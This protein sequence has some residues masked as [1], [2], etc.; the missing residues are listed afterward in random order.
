MITMLFREFAE[1][2][3]YLEKFSERTKKIMVL[4]EHLR[5]LDR[6]YVKPF[7]LL[8]VGKVFP[9]W[10][11]RS[12]D[13]S[14]GTISHVVSSLFGIGKSDMVRALK[15][16]GDVGDALKILTEGKKTARQLTLLS[17]ERELTILD[18][19]ETLHR[20]SEI[21]GED[22]RSRKE[23][24]LFTLMSRLSP[25]ELKILMRIIF[26]D[27]RHGVNVGIMEEAISKASG[28]PLEYVSRA[29]M[30][31]GDL[32]ETAEIA[33]F[34][35]YRAIKNIKIR[36]F[37]PI[38]PML[39][40]KAENIRDALR[41][42]GWK[43][44]FEFKLDGL[45]AQIHKRGDDIRIYSRRLKDVTESFPEIV[46]LI[47]EKIQAKEVVVEGEIIGVKDGKPIPFQFLMRRVRRIED[48]KRYMRKF[49]V[50]IYL[51]DI[52]YLDGEMLID[53]PYIE[54]RKILEDISNG[55]KLVPQIVTNSVDEAEDFFRRAI[56]GGHEGLV[57]KKPDSDYSPGT[58]GKKWLKIKRTLEPLDCVIVAAE[59]GY[60]RRKKWLSDYYLAVWDP[61]KSEWAIIGKTFKGLTDREF[62]E[63]TRE[64]LKAKIYE[65]GRTLF[66]RPEIVV[67]VIFDEIQKSPKYGSGY[68]LRFA[69]ISRIRYDKSPQD[70][71]TIDKV[72]RIYQSQFQHK[73]K[74]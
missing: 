74:I 3:E 40:Q 7:V 52:L 12:L 10:T 22:S 8:M 44:A 25:V 59:W 6:K 16:T 15:K 42:H 33:I 53:K 31:L 63:I 68:A 67:E 28:I 50:E 17:L 4:A 71:D 32:G 30:L 39:A 56:E 70:A 20:I 36:L 14:W 43:T 29:H 65:K 57:A 55:I 69:R 54:R 37:R 64:L 19:Y 23:K 9:E 73:A 34:S 35:G 72:R 26:G 51:F 41:E 18:V 47:R 62:E 2:C 11:Q 49:P 60:G 1:L 5:K 61:E 13:V 24:L 45:R 58:R 46:S 66:V 38:K 21:K 27:M 48:F